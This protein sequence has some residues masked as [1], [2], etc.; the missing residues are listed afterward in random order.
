MI[1]TFKLTRY[2][3]PKLAVENLNMRIE[4]G[5]VF[6]FVGPNGAGKTTTIRM[7]SCLIQ[8]TKGTAKV[9]GCDILEEPMEVKRIVGL[10][11]ENPPL[12]DRLTGREYLITG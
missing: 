7:L 1:E 5:E 4:G 3:G 9:G 6:G 11:L 10:V 2:Y 12:H 8:P